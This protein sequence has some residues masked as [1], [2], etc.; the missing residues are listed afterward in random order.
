MSSM[1]TTTAATTRNARQIRDAARR[2]ARKLAESRARADLLATSTISRQIYDQV[3]KVTIWTAEAW[4]SIRPE[5]RPADA[6]ES[7]SGGHWL[8]EN[9]YPACPDGPPLTSAE[10]LQSVDVMCAD[11]E[12][13]GWWDRRRATSMTE[14]LVEAKAGRGVRWVRHLLKLAAD[15]AG[16][17]G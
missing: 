10:H 14:A 17:I 6:T 1:M 9:V 11:W 8:F 7:H 4:E 15:E 13:G 16:A 5:D 2:D 12:R 3:E